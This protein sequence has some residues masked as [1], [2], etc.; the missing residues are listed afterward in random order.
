[1]IC[2]VGVRKR[3]DEEVEVGRGR[4]GWWEEA[5]DAE[6]DSGAVGL[7]VVGGS[8]LDDFAQG[9]RVASSPSM[10]VRRWG[11]AT[12]CTRQSCTELKWDLY[13]Q[14]EASGRKE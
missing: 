1:M 2:L 9:A 14:R 8:C 5:D 3:L 12:S 10:A 13:R 6:D 4:L 11:G 7:A